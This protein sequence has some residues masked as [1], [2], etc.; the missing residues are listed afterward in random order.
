MT[1]LWRRGRPCGSNFSLKFAGR[2]NFF[3]ATKKA[4]GGA[5]GNL[6]GVSV[7]QT[8]HPQ[9]N[10]RR[11][12]EPSLWADEP[13]DEALLLLEN[14]LREDE[15]ARRGREHNDDVH[16]LRQENARL[17]QLLAERSDPVRQD[18]PG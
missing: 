5:V 1:P 2:I 18:Q 6:I 12:S 14:A 13:T 17:R 8:N 16:W 15:P 4:T 3:P 9:R 11:C 7:M 10:K